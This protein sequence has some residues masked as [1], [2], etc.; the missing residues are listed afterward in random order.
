M[1]KLL[2]V[3]LFLLIPAFAFAAV[4]STNTSYLQ[5]TKNATDFQ[6]LVQNS[7]LTPEY[8]NIQNKT[9]NA[10]N[11][12]TL[13]TL[14]IAR[15]GA[16][17]TK[18]DNGQTAYGWGN[19]SLAGYIKGI[20]G[21]TTAD[22]TENTNLYFTNERVDD[23]VG[24]IMTN[25]SN[26]TFV[27]DDG[28]GTITGEVKPG[29]FQ[30][31]G[32][33]LTAI[34]LAGNNTTQL[35]EGTNLYY[36]DERV[37]DR[38]YALIKN[39]TG[40][41]W[42]YD[43]AGGTLTPT[44][45][46]TGTGNVSQDS[47]V[48]QNYFPMWNATGIIK[49]STY[50]TTDATNWNTAYNNF[51]NKTRGNWKVFYSNGTGDIIELALGASGYLKTNGASSAPSW[52]SP[53]G[54]GNVTKAGTAVAANVTEW[55]SDGTIRDGN[56]TIA[57]LLTT[58]ASANITDYTIV[59]ADMENF[60]LGAQQVSNTSVIR[61]GIIG[62]AMDGANAT[63][64]TGSLNRMML[65]PYNSTIVNWTVWSN[66]VYSATIEVWYNATGIPTVADKISA[67]APIKLTAEQVNTTGDVSTWAAGL[68]KNGRIIFN[69]T[70]ADNNYTAA[71]LLLRKDI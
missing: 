48:A 13:G 58:V 50:S 43:D 59:A 45:T 54:A 25:G 18:E 28:A 17:T 11:E 66:G 68:V 16:N 49:N 64:V 70:A 55:A 23:R 40:I 57:S 53:A 44:V 21:N 24:A 31:V 29:I 4:N 26:M 9:I 20:N 36:T 8:A 63:L 27:Y 5:W 47:A 37:D 61:T 19:H 60:T 10:T 69:I 15:G 62:M 3:L 39:G 46:A 65:V 30:P 51:L 67:T 7:N 2:L 38:A 22:L 42:A 1:K 41:T 35:T 12:I 71:T 56:K 52:D 32:S 34:T 14:P 33:Y 6:G